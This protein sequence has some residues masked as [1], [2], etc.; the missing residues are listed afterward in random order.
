MTCYESRRVS[1]RMRRALEEYRD[2]AVGDGDEQ[3]G[4]DAGDIAKGVVYLEQ[5]VVALEE[6]HRALVETIE[7]Q[8]KQLTELERRVEGARGRGTARDRG[9]CL[10]GWRQTE[11]RVA[12]SRAKARTP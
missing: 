2:E 1:R 3:G 9:R 12:T 6:V 5:R 8:A 10:R 11:K 7:A 4:D